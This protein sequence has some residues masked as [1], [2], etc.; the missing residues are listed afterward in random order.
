MAINQY[1]P[2]KEFQKKVTKVGLLLLAV[3]VIRFGIYPSIQKFFTKNKIPD[4]ITVKQFVDIDTDGD[5]LPDWE[6]SIWGT[7]PKKTDTDGDG[8]SDFDFVSSKKQGLQATN[9]NETTILSSEIMKTL[10]ALLNKGANTKDAVANLGEAAGQS[11]VKP[12]IKD[13]YA[14]SDLAVAGSSKNE[15]KNYYTNFQNAYK[16]FSKS[17]APDEFELLSVAVSSEDPDQ[18]IDLD[19]T[20]KK[21]TSFESSLVS[22][23]VPSDIIQTH[24]AFT[25]S[26]ASIVTALEK[27]KLLYSNSVVGINGIVELRLAHTKLDEQVDL[28]RSYFLRNGL[29]K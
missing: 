16:N 27:S 9:Q 11:I 2:S 5:G 3:V 4:N 25:N 1:L 21:H 20:I 14:V 10:F 8:V 13:K 17:K 15:V 29:I 18:L 24:L 6:E 23:K 12:E 28:L 19:D 7:N 26:V 22:M